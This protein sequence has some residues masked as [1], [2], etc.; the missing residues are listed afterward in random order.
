MHVRSR[1]KTFHKRVRLGEYS[2]D[3]LKKIMEGIIIMDIMTRMTMLQKRVIGDMV[4]GMIGG[5]PEGLETI[6]IERI[7]AWVALR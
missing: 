6:K 5:E 2:P 7:G 4:V 1:P 3:R